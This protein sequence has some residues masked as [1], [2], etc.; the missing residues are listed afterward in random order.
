MSDFFS[1]S[2]HPDLVDIPLKGKYLA[3]AVVLLREK[4]DSFIKEFDWMAKRGL[5]QL[6]GIYA[7]YSNLAD[8]FD[9]PQAREFG[10][11]LSEV[12]I[13]LKQFIANPSADFEETM[14]HLKL[15]EDKSELEK[16]DQLTD[17]LESNVAVDFRSTFSTCLAVQEGREADYQKVLDDYYADEQ[18][19]IESDMIPKLIENASRTEKLTTLAEW[20][21]SFEALSDLTA[22]QQARGSL[23]TPLKRY[24]VG[25]A[26]KLYEN[27]V[28]AAFE[29]DTDTAAGKEDLRKTLGEIHNVAYPQPQRK[30]G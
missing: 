14:D 6:G 7:I 8:Y 1:E 23:V 24:E 28:A 9:T 18:N 29:I 27:L 20:Y 26:Q 16:R 5:V 12:E 11:T 25:V 17:A 2:D 4:R 19:R 3:E 30:M 21:L 15:A 13:L 10:F 22:T